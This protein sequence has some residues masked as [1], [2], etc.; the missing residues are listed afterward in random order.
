MPSLRLRFRVVSVTSSLTRSPLAYI[1]SSIVRSRRPSAVPVSG[2]ASSASTWASVKV[3]GT[4]RG[5][6][7]DCSFSVGS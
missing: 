5:W 1:S 4:R 3:F 7:A 2:A 6:R